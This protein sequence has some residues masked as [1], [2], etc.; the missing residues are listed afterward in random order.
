MIEEDFTPQ[1]LQEL[2]IDR[3][4]KAS[5]LQFLTQTEGW[6]ILLTVF[7]DKKEA[8]IEELLSIPPGSANEKDIIAAHTIAYTVAHTANDIVNSVS[9]A[10]QDGYAAQAEIQ[11]VQTPEE[12]EKT[13]D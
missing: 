10:I 12:I 5:A 4:N 11:E 13:W 8:Q 9:R 7:E 1:A 3:M 6:K 2:A